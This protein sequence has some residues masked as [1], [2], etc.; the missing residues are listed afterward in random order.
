MSTS[1]WTNDPSILFNKDIIFE[2]WPTESMTME[3]KLNSITRLV[4]A[5]TIFSFI[6]HASLR[7]LLIGIASVAVIAIFY[8]YRKNKVEKVEEEDKNIKEGFSLPTNEMV[9]TPD[10][11]GPFLKKGYKMGDKKNPFSNVLLTDIGDDPT[12]KSAPPSFQPQVDEQILS[13]SKDMVQSVNPGIKNTN[14]Q[15]FSSLTDQ[16]YLDQS[17]RVFNSTAN[18][19]IANDQGAF[20]EWLYG[21]MPSAKD[22]DAAGNMQRY[23][24]SYRYTLY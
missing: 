13:D 4:L 11:L 21:N 20:A 1:F 16:F 6:F 3:E 8:F 24:D 2:L 9:I 5:V 22:S 18:T 17:L 12:R 19:R 14:K 15:L 23:A 7:I 10:S